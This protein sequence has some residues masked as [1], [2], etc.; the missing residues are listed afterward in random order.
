MNKCY[1]LL[2]SLFS[3]SAI[4]ITSREA[5][6]DFDEGFYTIAKE[7]CQYGNLF[8]SVTS[9]G[10]S[11]NYRLLID[12]PNGTFSCG[13]NQI[14]YQL[15]DNNSSSFDT[16]GNEGLKKV[17]LRISLPAGRVL[18]PGTYTSQIPVKIMKDQEIVLEQEITAFFPVEEQLKANVLVDG[19][20]SSDEGVRLQFG[21]IDGKVEKMITLSIK[22]NMN[23]TVSAVSKNHGNLVLEGEED[24]LHP[25]TIP[26]LL[27][28]RG[29]LHSLTSEVELFKEPFSPNKKELF[30]TIKF[31][32]TPDTHKT[33]HGKYKDQVYITISS[34]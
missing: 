25:A 13:F 9:G 29:A 19:Q 17:S 5:L 4:E 27:Q 24:D 16:K 28:S 10:E 32:L 2:C 8:F 14:E 18:A 3:L 6:L 12:K 11:C 1:L 20:L 34:L 30:S 31:L 22:A 21:T 33:F 15:I 26:Y 23:I 7:D